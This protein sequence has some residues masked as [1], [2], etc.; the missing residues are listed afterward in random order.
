MKPIWI[1]ALVIIVIAGS[2]Y[3]LS[4]N[5]AS[6]PANNMNTEV[7][8]QD[9]GTNS[10]GA[11]TLGDPDVAA[12]TLTD[13]GFSPSTV[14]VSVGDTVRFVNQSSRGMWVGSNE[15]P[16][17]TDYDGT[18]TREHCAGGV[19]TNGTFDECASAPKG[20]SWQY[21]FSKAGTF[22]YHNHVGASDTGTVVVE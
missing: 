13:S 2:W 3:A 20:S 16:T 11:V 7:S 9:T 17:H 19:T 8:F 10:S 18:S 6:A 15:H 21:T 1:I 5:R 4:A 14:T 12:V 22:G